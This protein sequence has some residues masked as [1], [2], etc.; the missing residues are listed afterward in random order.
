[1]DIFSRL[2]SRRQPP[3]P[4]TLS[5]LR[6]GISSRH[7]TANQEVNRLEVARLVA[8][9]NDTMRFT[10]LMSGSPKGAS[11]ELVFANERERLMVLKAARA[12][13]EE[14]RVAG[15]TARLE[16]EPRN[17][18]VDDSIISAKLVVDAV[19]NAG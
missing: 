6:A 10:T 7:E 15:V 13:I 14:L 3:E 16:T 8:E 19:K 1:M 12:A 11:V 18:Q 2:F 5:Q 4:S 9:V 17:T